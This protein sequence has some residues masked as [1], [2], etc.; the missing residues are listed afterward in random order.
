MSRQVWEDLASSLIVVT[1][2]EWNQ[3]IILEKISEPFSSKATIYHA[4]GLEVMPMEVVPSMPTA[5][6]S[7]RP[8]QSSVKERQKKLVP[9]RK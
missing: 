4:E 3:K 1:L 8:Q 2:L 9:M 6:R 7:P 5:L